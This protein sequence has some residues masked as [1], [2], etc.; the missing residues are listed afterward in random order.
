MRALITGATGLLGRHLLDRLDGAVVLSRDPDR[1]RARLGT[2]VTAYRWTADD[3]APPGDAF[4]GVDAVF[5]LAG[6][7]V[8]ERWTEAR[9][10]RIRQSRT[11][12][13]RSLV[14]AITS[15]PRPPTVLV[16]ASAVGYYGDRG[17]EIL[18]EN[19]TAGSDFLAEVCREWEAE[20]LR[21]RY[22]GLRVVTMRTGIVL[23]RDG[24][25]L[26]RMLPPFRLGLGGRLGDG[27]HWMPWVHVDDVVGMML[28]AARSTALDG[29]MN[30]VG[31]D[32]V[33]N[34]E[35]TRALG[36]VLHRPVAL[37]VPRVALSLLFGEMSQ[38]LFASQRAL[39][40]AAERA[41]YTFTHP[42]VGGALQSCV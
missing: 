11:A 17:D 3:A 28:L 14:A 35:F 37:P 1:A 24:G 38:I 16:S 26:P 30:A 19:A 4:D 6:E 33:R 22:H 42:D 25:A 10:R 18:D 29:P 15:S 40:R 21:A 2:K 31:P 34:T 41:G 27:R 12:G 39:P 36:H 13:T 23:A 20:A 32:P 7:P 8:G 5:H 9:K